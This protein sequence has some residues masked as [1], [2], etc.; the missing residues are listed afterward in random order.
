ME[1]LYSIGETAKIMGISVQTLR[2]YSSFSFLQ[3]AFIN[4][5]TGY[6]YYTFD[7]FHI[8][9][10]IKYLRSFDLS[11][12]EIEEVMMDGKKVDKIISF[13][14]NREVALEKEMEELQMRKQDLNWYIDYFK[15]LNQSEVNALPHITKHE[16]RHVLYTKCEPGESVEDIEIRLAK[17][18]NEYAKYGMNF[19]R[20]FG[21]LLDYED[22]IK[23]QWVPKGYFIYISNYQDLVREDDLPKDA[24]TLEFD[25]GDYLCFSFRLR[26]MEELNVNLIQEYFKKL[27]KPVW[28]IGNEHEDNL[29]SYKNCPYELQ[30]LMSS[31]I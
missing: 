11:L 17:L 24:T 30:F 15:Y 6:R 13:L 9:D 27:K 19:R 12:A 31:N 29:V 3:P 26:H 7:Q 10:R 22:I 18:K 2:N 28:V 1:K 14:E 25:Q 16:K 8:I 23:Q 4:E 21:Y 5:E 20:Q